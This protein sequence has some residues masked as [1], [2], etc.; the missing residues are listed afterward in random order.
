MTYNLDYNNNQS[1]R[2]PVHA[3][4]PMAR[5]NDL[6]DVT[7]N[8]PDDVSNQDQES[9]VYIH[10]SRIGEVV[11][12]GSV[13]FF[14][15]FA[16][17]F[18]YLQNWITDEKLRNIC[19]AILFLHTLPFS[20]ENI[21]VDSFFNSKGKYGTNGGIETVP[22]GYLLLLGG[23][24]WRKRY[25]E[26]HN[27]VDPIKYAHSNR[28]GDN[29]GYQKPQGCN[30]LFVDISGKG[31]FGCV[32]ISNGTNYYNHNKLTYDKI[33]TTGDKP[34]VENKLVEL[35]LEFVE[36]DFI[37]VTDCC[38]L[39]KVV[40]EDNKDVIKL[41]EFGDIKALTNKL[42]EN[43]NINN[44]AN[45]LKILKGE[46]EFSNGCKVD[47]FNYYYVLGFTSSSYLYTYFSEIN[48]IQSFYRTLM[49]EDFVATTIPTPSNPN[50]IE[51][52]VLTAYFN[53]FTKALQTKVTEDKK[54]ATLNSDTEIKNSERDFKCELYMSLKNIWDRWLC[55]Y[56]NQKEDN[57]FGGRNM[58]E[59]KNF[60]TKNFVFIDSFYSNI[61]DTLKLNCSKL[62]DIY[63]NTETSNSYLGKNVVNHLGSVVSAHNCMMF[64]FPDNVNFAEVDEKGKEEDMVKTMNEMF[65]P[66][67][68]NKI[69][70]PEYHNKFTI[71]YTHP[72][73][74]LDTVDR[75][76]FTPDSFDIWSYNDGTEVAPKPF[77]SATAGPGVGEEKY[78]N[79]NRIGYKV[80]A[81]GVAYSRQ[82]NS[83]WRNIGV[84]M[85]NYTVT[86][87]AI[88][89][90]AQIA[91][92]GNSDKKNITFYGQD[93][94]SLY[95]AYSYIVTVEM[96]GN[97]QIQP[98]M[99]FQLMNVPMFRGSYMIIKVEHNITPGHMTTTFT[100]MKM[101][102]VQ[103]PYTTAWFS[104]PDDEKY[105]TPDADMDA[106]EDNE[107]VM[108]SMEGDKI[109][110][111]D[112]DLSRAINKYIGK[113]MLCDEFVH[114]VYNDLKD[115]K[116]LIKNNSINPIFEELSHSNDWKVNKFKVSPR[117]KN[118]W[119]SFLR[120][121]SIPKVGD[122]LFGYH[123]DKLYGG[124]A[125]VAIYLGLHG[126]H[127]YVAEGLSVTG[128]KI[129]NTDNFVHIARIEDSRFGLES[130]I[131][132]HFS[133]C[134]GYEI[135]QTNVANE[136]VGLASK[137]KNTRTVNT[138][139]VDTSQLK[140]FDIVAPAYNNYSGRY[141]SE[142]KAS[143]TRTDYANEV[144]EA[145][146]PNKAAQECLVELIQH[147]LDP[148]YELAQDKGLG[149]LYVSS[150]YRNKEVN[151]KAGGV[152]DSQH[153]KGQAADIKLEGRGGKDRL[154]LVQEILMTKNLVFDQLIIE[155]VDSVNTLLP[156]WIHISYRKN[157]NRKELKY[158]YNGSYYNI[159]PEEVLSKPTN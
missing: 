91:E 89:A 135:Q 105:E 149:K 133:H 54:L 82:N 99:Y 64:N 13:M 116:Q 115:K 136:Y 31:I 125:H 47:N 107:E 75:N 38:E 139:V 20:Y 35:F 103:P 49:Y 55:G 90:E 83:F 44:I 56:Y 6:M 159:T 34:L 59:V 51:K 122:L 27:N 17:P 53:G 19:K 57:I 109:D 26:E 60:F 96:M 94:Y 68:A 87:Q 58:F 112:N 144:K 7:K 126:N 130:D 118:D 9:N 70:P 142:G 157:N 28:Q 36:N 79:T 4:Q 65:T 134:T 86:Q 32:L 41:M 72:A 138:I 11:S 5:I 127:K 117:R 141:T 81:F 25:M 67:A 129:Q 50:G 30:P 120:G 137:N 46:T 92:K 14:N 152:E 52:T 43:G 132:S 123:D 74:K 77:K 104:T 39:R 10:F 148:V 128:D 151:K 15:L 113:E 29:I 106:S 3:S 61:Y 143:L 18:Y 37:K 158:M 23:L 121:S 80:P 102:K 110:L 85:E 95:Q 12:G 69:L 119:S 40:N 145:N 73:N 108:T 88:M 156:K 22:Y 78:L 62:K 84:G 63:V 71:I 131:I 1:G 8:N 66:M 147:V 100:G 124:Y 76:K 150:G 33:V 42:N 140:H 93:I 153:M 154:K 24:I 146:V 2:F 48:P 97:A 111:A 21:D 16:H 155:D 98:L 114:K 45:S 101:S